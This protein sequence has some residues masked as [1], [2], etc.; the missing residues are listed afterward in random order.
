MSGD[1]NQTIAR[2]YSQAGLRSALDKHNA[3]QGLYDDAAVDAMVHEVGGGECMVRIVF[4][5]KDFK[6]KRVCMA[7]NLKLEKY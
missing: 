6:P 7:E 5:W 3:A 1:G 4:S 2:G